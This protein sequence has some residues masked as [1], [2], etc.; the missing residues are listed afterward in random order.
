M[1]NLK[2]RLFQLGLRYTPRFVKELGKSFWRL[3]GFR[4]MRLNF[5]YYVRRK[6]PILVYQVGK[7]GSKSVFYSLKSQGELVFHTHSLE[8]ARIYDGMRRLN[9]ARANVWYERWL[10]INREIIQKKKKIRVITLFRDPIALQVSSYFQNLER[11]TGREA[12]YETLSL[13]ELHQIFLEKHSD[14]DY[15]LNW[16]DG[17]FIPVLGVDIYAHPFPH[18]QGYNVIKQDHIEILILRLESDNAL[19][20]KAIAEFTGIADFKL[21]DINVTEERAEAEAYREF[22]KR[23]QVPQHIIDKAY[24]ARIT[25]YFYTDDEIAAMR[26]KWTRTP[27]PT[28]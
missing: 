13:E 1:A 19:K 28:P 15:T 25:R 5:H 23:V 4:T 12:A 16:F 10:W 21:T 14:P 6:T 9:S 17:D 24:T 2:Q 8:P 26:A 27:Q 22:K 3:N 18:E 20:Q 11:M 7:V